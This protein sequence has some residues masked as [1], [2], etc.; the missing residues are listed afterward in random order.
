[1]PLKS[2]IPMPGGGVGINSPKRYVRGYWVS[3]DPIV[4]T[5][6]SGGNATITFPINTQGHFEWAYLMGASTGQFSLRIYDAQANRDL[7]NKPINSVTI[8]GSAPRPFHLPKP[9]WFNVGGS[10]R[11]VSITV[12]DLSGATNDIRL[13]LYGRRLY[14]HDMPSDMADDFIRKF[15]AGP[16]LY[17]FFLVPKE[18][19]FDGSVVPVAAGAF[20][21]FMFEMDATADLE[22]DKIM[23]SSTGS[24]TFA[25]RDNDKNRTLATG[26]IASTMGLGV[27]EFPF[28]FGDSYMLERK[29]Q[30]ILEVTNTSGA[31]NSIYATL[32]GKRMQLR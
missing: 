27:A 6:A 19:K 4:A 14:H 3:P 30:L 23:F 31:S 15:D 24:F 32:A 1:M 7:Q 28:F 21:T 16:R 13:V 12:H 10:K 2:L 26:I 5:V 22:A 18:T 17:S 9:Y 29:K 25:L 8:V 20:E 11:E